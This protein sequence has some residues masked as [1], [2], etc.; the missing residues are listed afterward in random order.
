MR[1]LSL[2]L[3][4]ATLVACGGGDDGPATP[5]DAPAAA[6]TVST[7]S[8]NDAGALQGAA[9]F[10]AGMAQGEYTITVQGALEAAE[11]LDLLVLQ[12][13]T[14]YEPF[15]T[16]TAPT[17]VVP[18]TYNLTGAQTS[19][20]TCGVCARIATN[21]TTTSSEDDYFATGGSVTVGAVGDAVGET[22]TVSL[23]NVTF[24]HV[25]IDENTNATTPVGDGCDTQ[26]TNATFSGMV[27]ASTKPGMG[28]SP[29]PAMRT[30][31]NKF[32]R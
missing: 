25:T 4:P 5:V 32:H 15:G 27:M 23:S 20:A 29:S 30:A 22:L 12:F 14:G 1:K 2:F 3:L 31:A 6:C 21:A 10:E 18:G 11:P 26:I 9:F 13:Y 19:F 17:P 28:P 24:T 16:E 8:F 7:A